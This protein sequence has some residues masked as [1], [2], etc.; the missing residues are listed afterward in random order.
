[1]RATVQAARE[2]GIQVVLRKGL[3]KVHLVKHNA[4]LDP[5]LSRNDVWSS[6]ANSLQHLDQIRI[7]FVLKLYYN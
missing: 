1:M 5:R 3:R 6:P 7:E 2:K 4:Y